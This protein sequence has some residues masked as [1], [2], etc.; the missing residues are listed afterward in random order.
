MKNKYFSYKIFLVILTFLL[1]IN[2]FMMNSFANTSNLPD[3]SNLM[4]EDD[5]LIVVYKKNDV[6]YAVPTHDWY[7]VGYHPFPY[8]H[9]DTLW[10]DGN[11][12]IFKLADNKWIEHDSSYRGFAISNVTLDNI[13][14]T[15]FDL[16]DLDGNVV[17]PKAPQR[18]EQITIMGIQQVEEIPQIM[19]EVMKMIIPIGLVIFGIGLVIFLVRLV[20][21]RMR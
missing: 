18:V 15:N 11:V 2:I 20:I 10:V 1:F 17:F 5:P 6:Y 16:L 9:A 12:T 19:T 21:L 3:Y 7:V 8:H 14:Y 4:T 13:L